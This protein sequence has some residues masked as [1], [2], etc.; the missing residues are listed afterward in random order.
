LVLRGIL[1][2]LSQGCKWRAIDRPEAAWNSIYQYFRRWTRAGVFTQ[3]FSGIDLPLAGSRRF[4]DSTHVKVHRCASNP[5]GG[6]A[7]QAM[8]RTKGGLNTKIHAVVDEA[9][10]PVRLFLSAGH[11]ADISHAQTMAEEIPGAMLVADKGY[12]S[13]AFRQWLLERGIKPCI[14]PRSNRRNPSPYS[15]P[16]YR[17]RHVVENFFERIKNFRRV[18][19]RYDKLADTYLSFICLASTIVAML[20]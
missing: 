17:R 13:D 18:S 3:L 5:C 4:L 9:A 15:K 7:F 6:Q 14:P 11:E 2:V 12:D 1:I 19:T 20:F 10:Q 16:S 8:G